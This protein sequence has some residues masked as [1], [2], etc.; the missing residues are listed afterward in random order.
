VNVKKILFIAPRNPYSK[1]FSGDKI[2]A[3]NIISHLNKKIKVDVIYNDNKTIKK[4]SKNHIVFRK[5]NI[6]LKLIYIFI[7][8]IKMM[9][10]Q[11][12]FFYSSKIK[13]FVDL[14]YKNYDIIICH[15][16]RSVQYIPEAFK[17][18]K[19]LEMTD[20]FSSN[21]KQTIKTMSIFNPLAI[22]Y[23][24]EK[25]LVKKYEKFCLEFFD[26]IILV[27]KKEFLKSLNLKKSKKLY[28]VANGVKIQKKKFKFKNNNFKVLFTGNIKYL[29]NK[30]A[31][32]NFARQILPKI[33]KIYP[34]IEFHIIGEINFLDRFLLSLLKNT[35]VFGKMKNLTSAINGSIC[36][37]ANLNISTGSQI[38]VLTYA[39]FGLPAV[40]SKKVFSSLINRRK[41]PNFLYYKNEKQLIDLIIKLKEQKK[42]SE[43]ISSISH[44]YVK[45]FSW[46]KVLSKYSKYA[47]ISI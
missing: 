11:N 10:M 46:N 32:Y 8:L 15:L 21:Y 44:N 39:S 30:Y 17:G 41:K 12:G 23:Y 16:I 27:S 7:S 34:A 25:I 5:S 40:C 29:P 42:Y 19:I 38:K 1:G 4:N 35:K 36:G 43:K 13:K 31:C 18:K 9:P 47:G 14:N 26:K 45:Q 20:T 33:N 28:E 2:R 37:L 22:I 3:V 24:L 6:F